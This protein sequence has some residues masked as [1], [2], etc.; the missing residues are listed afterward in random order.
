MKT[1]ILF[2][3]LGN[4]CRSPAADGILRTLKDEYS[5]VGE[6]DSCGTAAYHVGKKP[7]SRMRKVARQKGVD[8]DFLSARQLA[9]SDFSTFDYILA[10][11]EENLANIKRIM[12][13]NA[14][15]KVRLLL[16]GADNLNVPDPYY[17]GEQGF[18]DCFELIEKG[19]TNFLEDLKKANL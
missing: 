2:V 3:C 11:D 8:L 14:K 18:V 16:E 12:P 15:S 17:G 1:S 13:S 10:M 7:D 19:L 5:F 9:V 6:V 4:I